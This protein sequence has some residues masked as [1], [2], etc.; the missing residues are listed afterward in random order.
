[1]GETRGRLWTDLGTWNAAC[2]TKEHQK[3]EGIMYGHE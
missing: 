2:V 1:L 3:Q